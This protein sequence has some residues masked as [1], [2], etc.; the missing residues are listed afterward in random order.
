MAKI[1]D[2][3]KTPAEKANSANPPSDGPHTYKGRKALEKEKAEGG[4]AYVVSV[5]PHEDKDGDEPKPKLTYTPQELRAKARAF[6]HSGKLNG[7]ERKVLEEILGPE[8]PQKPEKEN[9]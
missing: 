1:T 3:P 4:P 6:L 5:T 8:D 9:S 7:Q 2:K